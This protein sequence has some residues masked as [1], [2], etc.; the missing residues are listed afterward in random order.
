MQAGETTV[1]IARRSNGA[2]TILD[3]TGRLIVAP[4]HA[5]ILR[6]RSAVRALIAEGRV[7]LALNL[8]ALTAIDAAGIGELALTVAT[9]RE[10]GGELTLFAPAPTVKR[11]LMA[12]RVDTI[13]PIAEAEPDGMTGRGRVSSPAECR[14][15]RR[16]FTSILRASLVVNG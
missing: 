7:F 4:G 11:M 15:D 3:L 2:I 14:P 1:E 13:A 12:T 10:H 16:D 6:L 9:L 8:A 5:E